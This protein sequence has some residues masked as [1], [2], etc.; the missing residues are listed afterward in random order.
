MME[1]CQIYGQK[2]ES[3]SQAIWLSSIGVDVNKIWVLNIMVKCML[4]YRM[5]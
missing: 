3:K 4:H 5:K 1:V 2:M